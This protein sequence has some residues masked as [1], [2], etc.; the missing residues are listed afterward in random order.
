MGKVYKPPTLR[1]NMHIVRKIIYTGMLGLALA[2][3]GINAY[4]KALPQKTEVYNYAIEQGIDSSIATQLEKKLSSNLETNYK[5]FID[6]IS[7]YDSGLQKKCADSSILENKKISKKELKNVK[8][9]KLNS[10]ET[11][12]ENPRETY[13]VI[14]NGS[15]SSNAEKHSE[16]NKNYSL[17]TVNS[18]YKFLKEKGVSDENIT[19]LV[20]NNKNIF[21]TK[22]YKSLLEKKVKGLPSK[23]DELIV[24]GKAV[25]DKFLNAIKNSGADSNDRLLIVYH[26]PSERARVRYEGTTDNIRDAV[27]FNNENIS[28]WELTYALKEANKNCQEITIIEN[29]GGNLPLAE[30]ID[31]TPSHDWVKEKIKEEKLKGVLVISSPNTTPT[32]KEKI[33]N[34]EMFTIQLIGDAMN[35]SSL[36]ESL[37]KS[38][39]S[40]EEK[41]IERPSV[42]YLDG[43]RKSADE[44]PWFDKT[45]LN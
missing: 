15:G 26:S 28:P 24:D 4:R 31:V 23:E 43:F 44:C 11:E 21:D 25:K 9:K 5:E 1:L 42:V 32:F 3:C 36:E 10:T 33:L 20:Y 16:E 27:R 29:L 22:E 37:K 12:I 2:S 19:F 7:K 45:L 34:N 18:V 8:D 41:S 13:A 35:G 30:K 17:L 39:Y 6:T 40:D 38:N 14:A